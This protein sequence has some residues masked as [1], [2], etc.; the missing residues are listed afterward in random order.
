MKVRFPLYSKILLWLVL[1][2]VI[3]AL[4]FFV[5]VSGQLHLGLDF[6]IAGKAGERIQSVSEVVSSSLSEAPR[7]RWNEI[8]QRLG[9]S[10]HV[11]FLL[12]RN[13]GEQ[14]AGDESTSVPKAVLNNVMEN[15]RLPQPPEQVGVG[16]PGRP[17]RPEDDFGPPEAGPQGPL[18][19][20]VV[21]D[22]LLTGPH[23]RF[24]VHTSDPSQYWVGVRMKVDVPGRPGPSPPMTLL[25]MS[26]SLQGGGLFFDFV[27]WIGVGLGVLVVS[28][29]LWFPLVRGI[30][31]SIREITRAS[32]EVAAGNFEVRVKDGRN[33]ELGRLGGSINRMT[34]RLAG[35]VSGQ[36]RFLGDIAHELCTPIARVQM[37]LGV[38]E[39]RANSEQSSYVEDVREEVQHMS[40]LVNE[41]LSFSKAS[42][43]PARIKLKAVDLKPIIDQVIH[44][45]GNTEVNIQTEIA[46]HL[47]IMAE[48]DLLHRALANVLRNA[49]RYASEAGPI[50]ISAS[51]E[52]ANEVL[53]SIADSGSGVPEAAIAQLFDPFYRIDVSRARETGGVGL[54]L[55]IVKTCVESCG[56]QVSCRNRKPSGFEVL[57][58]LKAA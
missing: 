7:T 41:L 8:L 11:Q 25:I 23:S 12:Y 24:I 57:V 27:P 9:S 32:E 42:L 34:E 17:P 54:G 31:R 1:N 36:K 14:L 52:G 39:Q 50:V 45:E 51:K 15:R 43:E 47:Q 18:R 30:T 37:A 20:P 19:R 53:I 3:L 4:I 33:D 48:P 21:P 49:V 6:L 26:R 58:R 10:Y 46:E 35:F 22:P 56:G 13:D 28:A 40:S 55:A 29:L 38:L 2:F 5:F 16:E 44:R